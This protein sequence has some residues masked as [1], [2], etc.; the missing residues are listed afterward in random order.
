M[1]GAEPVK[2]V[3]ERN[4]RFETRGMSNRRKVV[5]LLHGVRAQQGEASLTTRHDVG[6][7]AKD[8]QRV[9]RQCARGDV[10]CEGRQLA[11]DP[12]HV[13]DHQEQ[14]LR[15]R[16][17]RRERSGLQGAMDR[18]GGAA[19]GLHLRNLG[20][21]PPEI[22]FSPAGPLVA[23]FSHRRTRRDREDGDCLAQAESYRRC[24]LV[25]VDSNANFFRR[26]LHLPV[27]RGL[28]VEGKFYRPFE[29]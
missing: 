13:R 17:R 26:K 1:R 3:Q 4:A 23:E 8:R 20:R 12:V 10:H 14:T 15:R 18:T 27:L 11:G 6:M 25:S 21:D 2:V 5:R 29:E 7:I 22:R 24:R 19:F 9:C 28:I 16:E